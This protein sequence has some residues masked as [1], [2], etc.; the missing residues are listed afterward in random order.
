VKTAT[1]TPATIDALTSALYTASRQADMTG[2]A[3]R[4][5]TLEKHS[6]TLE[7]LDPVYQQSCSPKEYERRV[8][9]VVTKAR[10]ALRDW[11]ARK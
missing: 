9:R 8:R 10:R 1:K 4:S 5:L 11:N 7:S 6:H 2:Y 3:R